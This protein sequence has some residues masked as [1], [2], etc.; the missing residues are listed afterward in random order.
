[1]I[2]VTGGTGTVG[3][4]T[5]RAL[6]ARGKP[7]KVGTRDPAKV[8]ASGTRAVELDFERPETLARALL[9]VARVFSL[10]PASEQQ[11]RHVET[12]VSAARKAGV[13]HVVRLSVA[14]VDEEDA[15][16]IVRSHAE[17]ERIVCSS[18]LAWT[19]LRPTFFAQN[20]VD[21]YGVRRDADSSVR[22]PHGQGKAAWVD[23]RDVGEVAAAAL[24]GRGHEGRVYELTGPEAIDDAQALALLGEALGR[25]YS[26]V[27]V[28]EED[29]RQAM[30]GAGVPA[31][32]VESLMELH[33]LI[34]SGLAAATASGV[35]EALGREARSFREYA[36]DLAAGAA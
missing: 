1:M 4:A 18:G 5:V 6:K 16:A 19:L 10:T 28:P 17:A 24:A 7:F 27:D 26:Y 8:K 2:L 32:Q 34:R 36:R 13:K 22:L 31:R 23:A 3:R 35:R 20:F 12:L 15:P 29:A 33:A 9:G 11:E 25:R 14:G 30:L 21:H